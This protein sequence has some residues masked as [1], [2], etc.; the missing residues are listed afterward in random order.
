MKHHH[1]VLGPIAGRLAPGLSAMLALRLDAAMQKALPTLLE[2]QQQTVTQVA[3]LL[4]AAAQQPETADLPRLDKLVRQLKQQLR[5]LACAQQPALRVMERVDRLFASEMAELMDATWAPKWLHAAEMRW[6]DKL[7][8]DLGNYDRWQALVLDA[9]TDVPNAR[10]EDVA[11]G[12]A[13]FLMW[14]AQHSPRPDLHLTASDYSLDYVKLGQAAAARAEPGGIP[15]AVVQRDATQLAQLAGQVDLIVCTQATH[16]MPPGLVA[17]LLHQGLRAAGHGVL[18]I[19]VLRSVGA[20]LSAA[21][22]TNLSTPAPPLMIDAMQSV[23]RGFLPAEFA[24]LAHLAGARHVR[25]DARGP[26]YAVLRAWL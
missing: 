25:A 14:M 5:D 4:D 7:N 1:A 24:L 6:L 21:T 15:L 13:G 10:I 23:R 19:D 3:E 22:G 8:R 2:Q 9:V 17:R 26:A 16:H 18:V 12:A 11:A 20:L